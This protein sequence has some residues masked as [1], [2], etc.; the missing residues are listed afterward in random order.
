MNFLPV[1]T[2][3]LQVQARQW[4][5]YWVRV[6]VGLI[7]ILLCLVQ[8]EMGS[9]LG[10]I[11][12]SGRIVFQGLVVLGFVIC[13]LG[14]LVT[15]DSI[16]WERRENTL[17]L[18]FLTSVSG[19][20]ILLGKLVSRGLVMACALT[21]LFPILMVPV[22]AGGVAGWEAVRIGLM[23]VDTLLLSLVAGLFASARHVQWHKALRASVGIMVMFLVL[24]VVAQ[25]MF[26]FPAVGLLS[27]LYGVTFAKQPGLEFWVSLVLV[28]ITVWIL[29]GRAVRRI[30][31][32]L[33]DE[34][35]E[36]G[37]A[38][39]VERPGWAPKIVGRIR[40]L[41]RVGEPVGWLLS[42]QRGIHAMIW[43]GVVCSVLVQVFRLVLPYSGG[44]G[45]VAWTVIW[46]LSS[47]GIAVSGVLF[48]WVA[49]R[50]LI[51][52]RRTGE[53]ETLI[54]TP[55]GAKTLIQDQWLYLRR[56]FRVPLVVMLMP[57]LF[58]LVV[59]I[60][61]QSKN[62]FI[63]SSINWQVTYL[64]S[65]VFWV[66][67]I[68][69]SLAALCWAGMWFGLKARTQTTAIFQTL[70]W[71]K[72]LPF[73]V[74]YIWMRIAILFMPKDGSLAYVPYFIFALLPQILEALFYLWLIRAMR[75]RLL[76]EIRDTEGMSFSLR[77]CFAG[78]RGLGAKVG[79]ARH[80]TPS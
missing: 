7:G 41:L 63:M 40:P 15:A 33:R 12:Q 55:V 79:R 17:G 74:S 27:P 8:M 56:M 70:A 57:S 23:M 24:P 30:Q 19:G 77:T 34:G 67:N 51:E 73:L 39:Q 4:P 62:S 59:M 21:A 16:S 54:T 71:V 45:R 38:I 25:A 48:A 69:L 53:L 11:A 44:A 29:Y 22:L 5:T 32:T 43:F 9:Q 49:S 66:A 20:D 26:P 3:E 14:C 58:Q 37:G 61:L 78:W 68:A 28:Q 2:R 72:V 42:R 75:I 60:S 31:L 52:S 35:N 10:D 1:I 76:G 50:F 80:W 13:C 6:F 65:M 36:A 46:P 47:L 18:L 64:I